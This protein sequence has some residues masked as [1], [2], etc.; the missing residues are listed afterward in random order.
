MR[1]GALFLVLARTGRGPWRQR[2]RGIPARSARPRRHARGGRRSSAHRVAAPH[3]ATTATRAPHNRPA[4]H[5]GSAAGGADLRGEVEV[6]LAHLF[7]AH[8]SSKRARYRSVSPCVMTEGYGQ[9]ERGLHGEEP[10]CT[11]AKTQFDASFP[12]LPGDVPLLLAFFVPL[13]RPPDCG[14]PPADC[15]RGQHPA[16]SER[17]LC[18]ARRRHGHGC[19]QR[20]CGWWSNYATA[21]R[22]GHAVCRRARSEPHRHAL[23]R[24]A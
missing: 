11:T 12:H 2:G 24:L 3:A 14:R 1:V 17:K 8:I 19:D 4:A 15:W 21:A 5:Q 22:E 6:V 13:G 9:L 18:G 7:A 16:A 20:A 23:P 10:S